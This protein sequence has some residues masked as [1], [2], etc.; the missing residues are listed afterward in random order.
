VFCE[1]RPI[2]IGAFIPPYH[3]KANEDPTMA[4]RR[5]LELVQYLD[6]LG[7]DEAWIGEH[8]SVGAEIV[9]SPEIFIAAAAEL[10]TR[11]RLG[12]GVISL[13]YHNPWMVAER[14]LQL[15]HQTRGRAMFG[16]GPG[17]LPSDADMLGIPTAESRSRMVEALEIVLRLLDGET[18]TAEGAWYKLNNAHCQ[19]R[20][21]THPRPKI[22]VASA[23]TPNGAEIAGKFDLGLLCMAATGRNGFSVLDVNWGVACEAAERE[24]RT[25]DKSALTVVGPM[26]LADT[27]EQ[28]V[29]DVEFG[30]QD[31]V[32]YFAVTA[33]HAN[34]AGGVT[35]PVAII[36][37]G[38]GGTIGTPD[39]AIATLERLWDKTG[40]FGCY[41]ITDTNWADT[42]ATRRSYEL[43]A[44]YVRPW[45][46]NANKGRTQ[47]MEA[48]Q[49][50]NDELFG[51]VVSA[52]DGAI[53]AYEASRA[54]AN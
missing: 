7:Y 32:D 54:P 27:K 12:T 2:S 36:E 39:D 10:T 37:Q 11:I 13:P 49:S 19:L 26:H 18:V 47:S 33:P 21:F 24:G 50:R 45:F 23:L 9:G 31:Y 8:H 1:D 15:D 16:F 52:A 51:R 6:E 46:T 3:T 30:L 53:K 17:I 4:I 28:A 38:F 43:F 41:L 14:V 20:P 22:K 34:E 5:D 35:D 48:Y 42:A 25:M 29:R 44:R 40:G